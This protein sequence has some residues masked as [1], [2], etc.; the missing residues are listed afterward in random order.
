MH[1]LLQLEPD[2]TAPVALTKDRSSPPYA[3]SVYSLRKWYGLRPS[4]LVAFTRTINKLPCRRVAP[5]SPPRV[6]GNNRKT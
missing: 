6:V 4:E 1:L 3:G 5:V 2:V